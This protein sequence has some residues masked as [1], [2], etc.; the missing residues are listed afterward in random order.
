M[1][2]PIRACGTPSTEGLLGVLR[3]VTMFCLFL[4]ERSCVYSAVDNS[5]SGWLPFTKS[6]LQLERIVMRELASK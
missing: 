2:Q 4:H 5:H 3:V 1:E 6:S